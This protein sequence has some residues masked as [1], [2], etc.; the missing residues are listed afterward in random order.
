M[1]TSGNKMSLWVVAGALIFGSIL[2]MGVASHGKRSGV[3]VSG[4][5]DVSSAVGWSMGPENPALELT[6]YADFQCPA[7]G[8][9][10]GWLK[11]LKTEFKDKIKFTYKHL[12]L[13]EVHKNAL[14]AAEAS[15]AAGL[16]GKFWEMHDLLFES[17]S[18]WSDSGTATKIFSGYAA[19]LGLDVKKFQADSAL[20]SIAKK[21][22]DSRE[23]G[24]AIGIDHTPTFF[25]NGKMIAN[26]T[27][28]EDF[29]NVILQDLGT[30]R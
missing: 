26:P 4:I 10:Y 19:K 23:A 5:A 1:N 29:R 7:C 12:P 14:A 8:L 30:N 27:S 20:D 17:Q 24:L 16:Q 13:T 2:I 18:E 9:Y 11:Q 15:E 3:P 6:E 28:Y 21:I 25:I 22:M